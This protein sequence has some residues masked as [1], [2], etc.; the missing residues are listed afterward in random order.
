MDD[1]QINDLVNYILSIQ[2]VPQSQNIC[3]NPPKPATTA[4]PSA[5]GSASPSASASPSPSPT[6]SP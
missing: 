6:S 2:K 5:S 4:S 3:V 1:Q